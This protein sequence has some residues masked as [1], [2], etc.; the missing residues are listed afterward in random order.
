VDSTHN[1]TSYI[2][3]F[4]GTG[5]PTRRVSFSGYLLANAMRIPKPQMAPKIYLSGQKYITIT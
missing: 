2:L 1:H 5:S 4:G 3:A